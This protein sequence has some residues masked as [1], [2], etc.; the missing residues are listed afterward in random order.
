[1]ASGRNGPRCVDASAPVSVITAEARPRLLKVADAT[2][3]PSSVCLAVDVGGTK[4]AA[5]L[6]DARGTV[7]TSNRV[8]TPKAQDGESCFRVLSELIEGV[9]REAPAL[10]LTVTACGVGSVGPMTRG[11]AS[12]SPLNIPAWRDFP[13]RSRLE[14]LPQLCSVPVFIDN[15]AKALVLGEFWVGAARG[16]ENFVAMVV[17]TGI[18]GGIMLDGRILDGE[19]G[20]AGHIGHVVV[21]PDGRACHCGSWGCLEAEASGSA[22]EDMTG[23]PAAYAPAQV[24]ERTGVLVGRAVASVAVLLDLRLALVGGSVALGFGERFFAAA[25]R[26][27]DARARIEHARGCVIGPVALGADGT[28]VGAAGLGWRGIGQLIA[29][30][31]DE[32]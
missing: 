28:L 18:G 5:G 10:A 22:I 8:G 1:M 19:N 27:I 31:R 6:V 24:I 12:V 20:N 7:V 16:V 17:S 25:Q 30:P 9:C 13:L 15:D 4:L 21:E 32:P 11:G 2:P 23:R 3:A 26:E 14:G 29:V